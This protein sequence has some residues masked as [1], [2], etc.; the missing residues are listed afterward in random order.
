MA[1]SF[2]RWSHKFLV[3]TRMVGKL[4]VIA[5]KI[6]PYL[7]TCP[8]HHSTALTS[9]CQMVLEI[10]HFKVRNLSKMDIAIL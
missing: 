4:A 6:K 9:M 1:N 10:S 7:R 3:L 5:E 8:M 2:N